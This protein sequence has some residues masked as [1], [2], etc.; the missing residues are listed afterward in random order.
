M[1]NMRIW[2]CFIILAMLPALSWCEPDPS[3]TDYLLED[4][5]PE[6]RLALVKE[7]FETKDASRKQAAYR[8]LISLLGSDDA[9]VRKDSLK[10]VH[11]LGRSV[12]AA[13]VHKLEVAMHKGYI[14]VEGISVLNFINNED[15]LAVLARACS[16]KNQDVREVAYE[17]LEMMGD[18]AQPI[19]EN[20]IRLREEG[21]DRLAVIE[22]LGVIQGK[23]A[24]KEL[25]DIL[26]SGPIDERRA[27]LRAL[28]E[29][30]TLPKS[31]VPVLVRA[32][33]SRDLVLHKEALAFLK[34]LT[35][36][37]YGVQERRR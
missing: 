21:H 30:E 18:E 19:V 25:A 20:L 8:D 29:F 37:D 11:S 28:Q 22:A 23:R 17:A 5:T 24:F 13:M 33:E 15:S 10:L 9:Q 1:G 6:Q 34:E 26:R 27:A 14:S 12:A 16:H 32:S 2:F 7:I 36:R 3:R 35:G 31:I 4:A